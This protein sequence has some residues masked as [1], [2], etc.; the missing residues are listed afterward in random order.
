MDGRLWYHVQLNYDSFAQPFDA[1]HVYIDAN[2][3][4]VV[5]M[6]DAGLFSGRYR[7]WCNGI[8]HKSWYEN[9]L[10]EYEEEWGDMR[11]W[12]YQQWACFEVS[13]FGQPGWMNYHYGVPD[14]GDCSLE[15]ARNAALDYLGKEQETNDRWILTSSAYMIDVYG[16]KD[17]QLEKGN[18][19]SARMWCLWFSNEESKTNTIR[20]YVDPHDEG[21]TI[22]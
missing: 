16:D 17:L 21:V 2:T 18:V 8:S 7:L 11:Q 19:F 3:G 15:V 10:S 5:W 9:Q 13:C 1:Y 6:T 12:D 20:V 4:E 14:E 22:L